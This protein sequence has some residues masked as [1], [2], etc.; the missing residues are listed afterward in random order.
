[1]S[2]LAF[3]TILLL[4]TLGQNVHQPTA[5]EA[6][7]YPH[8]LHADLPLYP[9][10]A[11][12]M[13][14]SGIV[15]IEVTVEKGVVVE[16]HVKSVEIEFSD[17]EKNTLYDSDAKKKIGNQFLS[18]PSVANLKTWQFR[19]EDRATFL[20]TYVYKIEGEETALPENP[21]IELDLPR[22]VKITARPFK[23]PC[24]D[25]PPQADVGTMR[26]DTPTTH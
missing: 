1:M 4:T 26:E 6:T 5:S 9:P 23:P 25:C 19:S 7:H 22:L 24:S 8:I 3:I 11:S 20:V 21:K 15:K 16:A 14:I 17:P 18:N 13:R 10:L 12:T 2:T